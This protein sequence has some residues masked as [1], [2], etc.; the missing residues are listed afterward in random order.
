MAG[1]QLFTLIYGSFEGAA[2][3]GGATLGGAAGLLLG[4]GVSLW[5]VLRHEGKWAG[6]AVAWL[7]VGALCMI[8][9]LGFVAFS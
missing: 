4:V 6:T 2:A 5:L 1:A 9:C 7:W 8:G 3:M